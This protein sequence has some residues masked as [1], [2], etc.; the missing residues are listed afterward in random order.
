MKITSIN[1]TVGMGGPDLISFVT[2]MPNPM[3]PFELTGAIVDT[4][5]A[6]GHGLR[7]AIDH[8]PAIDIYVLNLADAQPSWKLLERPIK[9]MTKYMCV[10]TQGAEEAAKI[11]TLLLS[12]SAWFES[13]PLP[14][15]EY[16]IRFKNE[17]HL[18][19]GIQEECNFKKLFKSKI[20]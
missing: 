6:N 19:S 15:D 2:D 10:V 20:K 18:I 16:E 1:V 4:H 14:M 9:N 17:P 3:W 12:R 13:T 11:S 8:F 7:Y 5:A